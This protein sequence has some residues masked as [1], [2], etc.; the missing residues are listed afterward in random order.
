MFVL[1]AFAIAQW[2]VYFDPRTIEGDR[3]VAEPSDTIAVA[4]GIVDRAEA[5][6][7]EAGCR[8]IDAASALLSGGLSQLD[9]LD[10]RRRAGGLPPTAF[11]SRTCSASS[12]R[13]RQGY[14]RGWW[15]RPR[16]DRLL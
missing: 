8:P 4:V 14:G 7:A 16:R 9:H 11:G 10:D 2:H 13:P 12:T 6:L 5:A 15:R 1:L 3:A